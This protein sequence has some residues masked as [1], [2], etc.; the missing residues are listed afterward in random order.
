MAAIRQRTTEEKADWI[1]YVTDVG[2]AEHFDM[3]F[4]A[5]R[6]AGWLPAEGK[7]K[8]R[9]DHCGFGLV[10]GDDGKRFRTRSS[11]VRPQRSQ[12]PQCMYLLDDVT[13]QVRHLIGD[14]CLRSRNYVEL[15]G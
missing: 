1:I 11:E 12:L 10:L 15:L 13:K 14:L 9:V 5:A 6:M 2:Q 4:K 7:G 8:P 3:V